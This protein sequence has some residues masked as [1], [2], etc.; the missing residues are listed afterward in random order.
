MLLGLVLSLMYLAQHRRLKNKQSL[1]TGLTLP[2]L[3]RLARMNWWAVWP[4]PGGGDDDAVQDEYGLSLRAIGPG[5]GADFHIS[6]HFDP[7]GNHTGLFT[8]FSD[9]SMVALCEALEG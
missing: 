4:V 1:K 3:E 5:L 2:S 8:A 6:G 7:F 9:E